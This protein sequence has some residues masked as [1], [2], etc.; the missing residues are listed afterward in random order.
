MA[1]EQLR[2]QT[3]DARTDIYALG[4]V[5]YEMATGRRPF[6]EELGTQL[7]DDI[8][9]KAPAPPGRLNPDLSPR[10]DDVILKCL[11]KNPENRYQSAKEL[12]V[13]LRRLAIPS[14][15]MA[16]AAPPRWAWRRVARPTIYGAA[17]LLVL[18]ALLVG[19]NLGGWRER[20]LNARG[21]V[22]IDSLAVLPFTIAGGNPDTEYLSDGLTE[23]L[24][25]KLSELPN[26]R[27]MARS[28]MF[29]YKGK[30]VDPQKVGQ[31][32]NVRVVLSGRL[33]QR[34]DTLIVQADLMDVA[35]GSQLWGSQYVRKVADVFALQEDLSTEISEKLRLRLTGEEKQRLTKRYTENAEAYQLYLKGRY[36]LNK[37]NPED[38]QKA[39]EYFQQAIDKDPSYAL[40]YAGLADTYISRAWFGELPPRGAVPKV[41][42]AAL[43]ALAVDDRIAEAHVSVAFASFLYDWDWLAARK[44]FE[45]ALSLSPAFLKAQPI[46][47]PL[48]SD[49]RFQDLLRRIGLPP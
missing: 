29:R 23:S 44:H 40:A 3:V 16:S 41:K 30:E 33:L 46:F 15:L 31:D 45:R 4:T 14:Q 28:T 39:V 42:A 22:Q 2:G 19:S 20:L 13:D 18:A 1:P 37:W 9:H 32:L 24:I 17:G 11:E 38:S 49:P 10:L 5:L 34:G 26:L 7:I 36:F 6:R 25:D 12:A 43:K 27:V 47:E 21:S 35:K 48:R 8:L